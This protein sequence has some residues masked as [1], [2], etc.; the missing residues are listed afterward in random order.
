[1]PYKTNDF[2]S[3]LSISEL[4]ANFMDKA[5]YR[6]MEKLIQAPAEA[7]PTSFE[8]VWAKGPQMRGIDVILHEGPWQT[9]IDEKAQQ[10]YKDKPLETFALELSYLKGGVIHVGWL[11]DQK[12][13][14]A[15]YLFCWP[16]GPKDQ[17]GVFT[18]VRMALVYSDD[19]KVF[20]ANLGYTREVLC[21]RDEVIREDGLR[22]RRDSG[23]PDFWFVFS[24]HLKEQPINVVV[25]SSR[26]EK[27]AR[28]VMTVE[29]DEAAGT[30]HVFGN[31]LGQEIDVT[32]AI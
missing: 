23:D 28:A 19:V 20:L 27:L 5:F 31:W 29:Y 24:P 1:M 15:A 13:T 18:R 2:Q 14:T 26:L 3:D 17:P 21:K 6:P 12:K 25:K 10:T 7:T 32:V 8:R 30:S 11:I 22:G 4:F 9:T 16:E